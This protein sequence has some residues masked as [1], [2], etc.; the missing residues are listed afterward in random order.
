MSAIGH[1]SAGPH[2]SMN[3]TSTTS[4]TA[5]CQ[6]GRSRPAR[7]TI[8]ASSASTVPCTPIIA[9]VSTSDRAR[10][11]ACPRSFSVL[12][13]ALRLGDP[14]LDRPQLGAR[15][16]LVLDEVE[17]QRLGLAVE[18]LAHELAQPVAQH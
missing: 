3:F 17:H 9:S 14:P 15:Q 11:I 7:T 10:L 13:G 12:G 1:G 18:H 2:G 6:P 16:R 4:H 5:A 8:I